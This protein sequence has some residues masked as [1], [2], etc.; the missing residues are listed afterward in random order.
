MRI[1]LQLQSDDTALAPLRV[2]AHQAGSRYVGRHASLAQRAREH[3]VALNGSAMPNTVR[4]SLELVPSI[5]DLLSSPHWQAPEAARDRFAGAL[6][7]FVQPDD[8]IPDDDG[9]YGY[10]DDA[11]VLKLALA[12]SS[13]EWLAWRDYSDYVATH[14]AETGIDRRTWMLHRRERLDVE[15]RKRNEKGYAPDGRRSSAFSDTYA[16]AID[17]PGRFGVR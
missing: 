11:F 9:R 16:P 10:L 6:A 17:S 5:A 7:Y 14:P 13:H 2:A 15:L 8:L 3:H 12:E 4:A 1:E